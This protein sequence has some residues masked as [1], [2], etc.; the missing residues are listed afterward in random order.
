M[1]RRGSCRRAERPRLAAINRHP[2]RLAECPAAVRGRSACAHVHTSTRRRPT[3]DRC[4]RVGDSLASEL[5][6]RSKRGPRSRGGPVDQ[7]VGVVAESHSTTPPPPTTIE[8]VCG[9]DGLA[10]GLKATPLDDI[11]PRSRGV[12]R[13]RYVRALGVM[14]RDLHSQATPPSAGR[15]LVCRVGDGLAV[16]ADATT[17][18]RRRCLGDLDSLGE[19]R[20]SVR[21]CVSADAHTAP[22]A[23]NMRRRNVISVT[24]RSSASSRPYL[25][26]LLLD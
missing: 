21:L 4:M 24:F 13:R 12:A 16:G 15:Q 8:V 5:K 26:Q 2:R 22:R 9:G 10:A 3:T 23:A 11:D 20:P 1:R 14:Y 17:R 25:P 6:A 19:C 7:A 18:H